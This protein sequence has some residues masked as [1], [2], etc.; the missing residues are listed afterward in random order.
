MHISPLDWMVQNIRFFNVCETQ[1]ASQ[2]HKVVL[3]VLHHPV[4]AK[5]LYFLYV[6]IIYYQPNMLYNLTPSL[7]CNLLKII[8]F[9]C[10]RGVGTYSQRNSCTHRHGDTLITSC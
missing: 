7:D 2:G 9:I 1:R 8:D 5:D 6:Y 3:N 10:N 4:Q